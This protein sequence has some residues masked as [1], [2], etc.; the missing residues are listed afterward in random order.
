MISTALHTKL[1]ICIVRVD[2]VVADVYAANS[3]AFV[4]QMAR[5]AYGA[6]ATYRFERSTRP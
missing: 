4:A 1:F 6:M 2:G 3:L 5:D